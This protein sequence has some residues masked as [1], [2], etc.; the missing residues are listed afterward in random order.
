MLG[1]KKIKPL[2]QRMLEPPLLLVTDYELNKDM[3]R[4]RTVKNLNIEKLT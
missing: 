3:F 4:K 1:S 2:K